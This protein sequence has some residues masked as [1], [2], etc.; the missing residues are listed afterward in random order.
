MADISHRL[1]SDLT[2]I[3]LTPM[4]HLTLMAVSFASGGPVGVCVK[5]QGRND[6]DKKHSSSKDLEETFKLSY[7]SRRLP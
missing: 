3:N 4:L 5:G 7:F 6:H 1:G 2:D